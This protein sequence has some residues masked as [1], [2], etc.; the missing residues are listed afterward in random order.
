MRVAL[1]RLHLRMPEQAPDHRQTHAERQRPGR[2]A[3]TAVVDAD[4]LDLGRLAHRP[5][6]LVDV[7]HRPALDLARDRPRGCP[8]GAGPAPAPA[9]PPAT[10]GPSSDP[11]WCPAGEARPPPGPPA[12]SADAGSRACGSPSGS[13]AGSPPPSRPIP[14]LPRSASSSARPSRLSSSGV[15]NR[16]RFSS[17]FRI[18]SR[19]GLLPSA[20]RPLS[21]AALYDARERIDHLVRHHRRV[22]ERMMELRHPGHGR[23]PAPAVCR[24]PGRCASRSP[25]GSPPRSSPCSAPRRGPPDSAGRDPP[26]SARSRASPPAAPG[27]GSRPALMRSRMSPA[28][29]RA[30]SGVMTPCS[31]TVTRCAALPPRA[32]LRDVDLHPRRIH[33]HPEAGELAVPEH[34]VLLD[35]E[36]LHR[37]PRDRLRPQ[38]GHA[39][40]PPTSPR[41]RPRR[42]CPRRGRRPPSTPRPARRRAP[43]AHSA[44]WS[45][46]A[47]ARGAC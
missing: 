3:V 31:P 19:H 37:A 42:R 1:C 10:A 4:V 12:P 25:A 39:G 13:A 34:R 21:S 5:P 7:A 26:P 28:R 44:R 8:A 30:S 40:S 24:A 23:P 17:R 41:P 22:A 35:L 20:I 29:R 33:P 9:P 16:S 36:R 27:T 47:C 46:N 32:G 45:R 11:S 15:R 14:A 38:P 6:G 18:T 43:D 2:E